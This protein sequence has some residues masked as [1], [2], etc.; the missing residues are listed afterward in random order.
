MIWKP[1]VT[2]AAVVEQAG[3]FLIV[4]EETEDGVRLN[5]PAGHLEANESLIQASIREALEE[6]GRH[7]MPSHVL[8]V[9]RWTHPSLDITYLRFAFSG[10][11]GGFE[12]GRTLDAGILRSIG[13]SADELRAL[14]RRVLRLFC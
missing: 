7:F 8:G 9:Y 11:F 4:E 14:G 1:H 13:L 3:R 2:V 12:A 10:E 6:T 5:Q